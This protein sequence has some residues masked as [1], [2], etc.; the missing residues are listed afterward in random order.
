MKRDFKRLLASLVLCAMLLTG[1]TLPASAARF[2]DVPV[3]YWAAQSILRCADLG[4][5]QGKSATRFGVGEPMTR[6][7]FAVV[8]CRLFGWAPEETDTLPF[9]DV[10]A[11]AWYAPSVAAALSHGAVTVQTEEFRPG[12][13]LTREEL[14][15]AL[16]RG[17][18]YAPIS[19]LSQELP[20]PFTDVD[21]NRGYITMAW[22][23]GLVN[24]TSKTTFSPEKL[25]TREQCAVILMRLYDKLQ[26]SKTER[27]GVLTETTALPELNGFTTLAVGNAQLIS[28]APARVVGGMSSEEV[29]AVRAATDDAKILLRVTGSANVFNRGDAE[30]TASALNLAMVQGG[31]DGVFLDIP[32]LRSGKTCQPLNLLTAALKKMLGSKLLYVAAE[33]PDWT[34][35]SYQGYDYAG[36]SRYA[37]RL[38]LRAASD[39]QE[40]GIIPVAP[41]QPVENV[42]YGLRKLRDSGVDMAKVSLW[43]TTTANAWN[44][45]QQA[46]PL[47]GLEVDALLAEEKTQQYYSQRYGCSYLLAKQGRKEWTVWYPDADSVQQRALL[48]RLFGANQV[49]FGELSGM[50]PALLTGLK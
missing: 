22:D 31:Y 20:L 28:G 5:F 39:V 30:S 4:L 12:D 46:D 18:G 33:A 47:T 40:S 14:A 34:E 11:D 15:A 35:Q 24:G 3:N 9:T 7:G 27:M 41:I 23:M 37:D 25:A 8:L 10:P 49:C 50:S 21:T 19:G 13:S 42:Y 2:T 48:G 26:S 6:G 38:V 29:S 44:H 36:I 45:T 43:L 17:L 1:L 16:I 32:Q